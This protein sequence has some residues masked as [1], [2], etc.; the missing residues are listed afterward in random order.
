MKTVR[1]PDERFANLAG[2]DF[3]PHYV[4]IDD[5]DGETLRMHYVDEGPRDATPVLMLHGQPTWSYLYRKMIPPLVAAGYRCLA[6]DLVGFGRSDKP[7]EKSD[8]TVR[9]HV[10]WLERWLGSVDPR[11]AI[12]FGQDWGSLLGLT[13][14]ARDPERF[15][16]IM[17]ANGALPDPRNMDRF[18]D[19]LMKG[20][21]NPQAFTQWQDWIRDRSSIDVSA[22][23]VGEAEGLEWGGGMELKLT[24]EERRAY[25][26]PFPDASYQ[27]GALQ[28]PLLAPSGPEHADTIQLFTRS[29]GRLRPVV[30]AIPDGLRQTGPG[31]RIR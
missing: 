21:S 15:A 5:G 22:I 11:G 1:T 31:A 16:R 4:D 25:D 3:E 19:A 9:R 6:P 13:V 27:A 28:F 8:Y 10:E 2:Y 20:S 12:Y 17:I 14:V 7:T 18:I 29:L 26:A 23:M 30:E 24:A